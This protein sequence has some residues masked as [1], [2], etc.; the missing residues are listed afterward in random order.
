MPLSN[1][2]CVSR[3]ILFV[4]KGDFNTKKKCTIDK[5]FT[6]AAFKLNQRV[7]ATKSSSMSRT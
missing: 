6:V 3:H 4:G 7:K 2:L 5:L 1:I